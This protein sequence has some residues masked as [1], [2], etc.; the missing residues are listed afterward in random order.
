MRVKMNW[1][2]VRW[3]IT[4]VR[5]RKHGHRKRLNRGKK[6]GEWKSEKQLPKPV[7][8]RRVRSGEIRSQPE[9]GELASPREKDT[10]TLPLSFSPFHLHPLHPY[11]SSPSQPP[12]SFVQC[13]S[14]AS[15]EWQAVTD[16]L[17]AKAEGSQCACVCVC[18]SQ[19]RGLPVQSEQIRGESKWVYQHRWEPTDTHVI[20]SDAHNCHTWTQSKETKSGK[21]WGARTVRF[22]HMLMRT[23]MHAYT[24]REKGVLD[25]T[26]ANL[27]A[28]KRLTAC[29]LARDVT[30]FLSSKQESEGN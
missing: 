4:S 28:W 25:P 3:E 2:L 26:E 21:A 8:W 27:W 1:H 29:L 30:E 6:R 12:L 22:R 24:R 9:N 14:R 20:K 15:F 11:P 18:V 5:K 23:H 17:A 19:S 13:L 10:D 7:S 16:Q